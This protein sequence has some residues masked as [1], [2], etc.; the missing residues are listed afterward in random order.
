MGI[1]VALEHGT[2]DSFDRLRPAPHSRTATEAYSRQL[3]FA[4]HVMNWRQSTDVGV[5]GILD[6]RRLRTVLQ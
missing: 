4:D 6:L 2:S 3:E 1:K 5:P